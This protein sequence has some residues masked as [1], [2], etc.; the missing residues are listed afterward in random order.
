MGIGVLLKNIFIAVIGFFFLILSIYLVRAEHH[1][2]QLQF[3]L[4][5]LMNSYMIGD[6]DE[7]NYIKAKSKLLNNLTKFEKVLFR[8]FV[9][10]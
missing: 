9:H 8:R 3:Y 5:Q 1:I 4:N 7:P 6:I 10:A 2:S